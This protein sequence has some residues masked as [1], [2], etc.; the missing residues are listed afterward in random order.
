MRFPNGSVISAFRM[1]LLAV[2]VPYDHMHRVQSTQFPQNTTNSFCGNDIALHVHVHVL[3]MYMYV[4][5]RTP[6]PDFI[7]CVYSKCQTV[8]AA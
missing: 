5:M 8:L 6:T 2:A 7:T 4:Y 1:A 3:Y